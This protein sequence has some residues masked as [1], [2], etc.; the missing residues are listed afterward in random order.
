MCYICGKLEHLSKDCY[1]KDKPEQGI[2]ENSRQNKR[3][4]NNKGN[5][6]KNTNYALKDRGDYY[7]FHAFIAQE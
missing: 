6:N 3:D 4:N 7:I 1:R 5:L 2:S